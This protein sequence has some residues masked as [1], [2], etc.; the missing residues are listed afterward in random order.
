MKGSRN[1]WLKCVFECACA[2]EFNRF[3]NWLIYNSVFA[4][5]RI[6]CIEHLFTEVRFAD[7]THCAKRT[8]WFVI[9]FSWNRIERAVAGCVCCGALAV[10]RC[11]KC[12][13]CERVICISIAKQNG[14]WHQTGKQVP[15]VY[16]RNTN[17]HIHILSDVDSIQWQWTNG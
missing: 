7:A 14:K 15:A 3:L 2:C 10:G 11:T 8:I 1:V 13:M 5:S 6:P 16:A 9:K 12:Y 4:K 17:K